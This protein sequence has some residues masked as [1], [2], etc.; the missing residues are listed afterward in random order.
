MNQFI[1]YPEI[2]KTYRHYKGGLY[3]VITMATHT[4]TNEPLVI[5]QSLLFGSILAR[6]LSIWSEVIDTNIDRDKEPSWVTRFSL[7]Y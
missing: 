4:E 7:Y 2:G 3:K 5:Y 1:N 6:P